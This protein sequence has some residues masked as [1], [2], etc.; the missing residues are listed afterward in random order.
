MI[1][2]SASVSITRYTELIKNLP[3]EDQA[4]VTKR[5]TWERVN[6][7]S[8]REFQQYLN[9]IFKKNDQ[10]IIS[11]YDIFNLS[12][13]SFQYTVFSTILWGYPRNM[14]G[15][16]ME[17]ILNALPKL[18][19]IFSK[20]K[21]LTEND[22]HLLLNKLTGTGIGLS[23]LTKLLYF[24]GYNIENYKCLILDQRIVDVLNEGIFLELLASEFK[25]SSANKIN[26]IKYLKKM[27]MLAKAEG[28]KT[29]Q[30]E[31]FLFQFGKNFKPT[32]AFS[33]TL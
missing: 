33:S 19:A 28:Y 1:S 12:E 7:T 14:R 30:L 25:T 31:L 5:S 8:C 24:F 27:E 4:F 21:Q 15:N 13:R 17:S 9:N 32:V 26:Y 18:K 2:S 16:A 10:I 20:Q 23:T 6:Y 3:Y 22:F 11:R 29:D